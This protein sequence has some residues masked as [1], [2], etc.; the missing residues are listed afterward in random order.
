MAYCKRNTLVTELWLQLL[1]PLD[2]MQ[3]VWTFLGLFPINFSCSLA[4]QAVVLPRKANAWDLESQ[5][6]VFVPFPYALTPLDLRLLV[7]S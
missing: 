3:P 5:C 4:A 7:G 1:A 6:L 2:L